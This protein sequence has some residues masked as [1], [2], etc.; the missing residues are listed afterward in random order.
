M[1]TD[2]AFSP[3]GTRLVL[4]RFDG[5]AV[6][7]DTLTRRQVL[8]IDIGSVVTAVA[9]RPAGNL[10]RRR[11][12]RRGSPVLRSEERGAVGSLVDAG[13]S[14]VWQLAFSPDGRL[15]AVVVDPNGKGDGFNAQQ[16]NGEVQLWDVDSRN[17]VGREIRPRAGSVL[18]V[19]F[20]PAGTLLAT[21]SYRGRLDL[22]DV[23]TRA[24]HGKPMRVSDDA[25]LS[26]AFDPSGRLV[27]GGGAIGPVRVW[28]VADQQRAFPPLAGHS[29]FVTG[30][31]VRPDRLVPRNHEPAR[32]NEAVGPGH[33]SRL[34]RRARR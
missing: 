20:N 10:D 30:A 15:L 4:G 7:Y 16:R 2:V 28:R 33:G 17:R 18:S 27:A 31:G 34:W 29:G 9:F 23:A 22:W 14:A 3:D 5:R 6:V 13:S 24:H 32:R 25:F 11:N 26:V 19:A 21:G 8:R 1:T 12:D